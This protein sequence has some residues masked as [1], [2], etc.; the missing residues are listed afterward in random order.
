MI[1]INPRRSWGRGMLGTPY[2]ATAQGG[3][4]KLWGHIC[5]A[6]RHFPW[7]GGV[8]FLFPQSELCNGNDRT[9]LRLQLQRMQDGLV[10]PNHED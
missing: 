6:L 10:G 8:S 1:S 9:N 5:T 2:V 7:I 3:E 4:D